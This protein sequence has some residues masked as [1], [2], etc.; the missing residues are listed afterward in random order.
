[1]SRSGSRGFKEWWAETDESLVR[2]LLIILIAL[3][4][5]IALWGVAMLR[6]AWKEP[7]VG[8]TI[9]WGLVGAG[10]LL[11]GLAWVLDLWGVLDAFST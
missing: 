1:M 2:L 3:A 5:L 6:T 9:G 7:G 4:A 8:R 11:L 10:V